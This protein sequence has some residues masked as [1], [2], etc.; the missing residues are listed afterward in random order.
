MKKLP[1]KVTWAISILLA[2]FFAA[3]GFLKLWGP[4]A[5]HWAA[6]F[7]AWGYPAGSHYVVGAIEILG[8]LALLLPV[9][10]LFGAGALILVMAGAFCTH[11]VHREFLRTIPPVVLGLLAYVVLFSGRAVDR[12]RP[13]E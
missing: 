5:G 13:A 1:P 12:E 4:A 3:Q 2:L 8:A 6:R 7:A 9:A 11:L 10:R